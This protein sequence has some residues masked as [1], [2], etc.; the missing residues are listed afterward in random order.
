MKNRIHPSL[1]FD[2]NALDA[3]VF[4]DGIFDD[5][6]MIEEGPVTVTFEI[7][8]MRFLCI[9]GGPM[10]TPNPSISFY[11]ECD[12][13]DEINT[14][15]HKLSQGGKVLMPLQKYDWT[16]KYA[17]I[18]DKFS[19]AWQLNLRNGQNTRPKIS[20]SLLFVNEKNGRAGDAIDLYTSIFPDGKNIT[21]SYYGENQGNTEGYILFSDSVINDFPFIVMDG[22]GTHDFDFDEGV[23]FVVYTKDQKET[24]YMWDS[25]IANGGVESQCG[26]LK[27]PFGVSWQIVPD[28]FMELVGMGPDV[29]KRVMDA[30]MPMKRI[31]IADMEKAAGV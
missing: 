16:P 8:G 6:K 31:V 19:V 2:Q 17:F 13:E 11:I 15:Y 20:P 21:S 1:W 25:L 14:K 29:F 9:N 12:S 7:E 28:R 30:V 22:P 23:S 24:D 3:S 18:Q 27:D 5:F 26:W 4:Y 10:F